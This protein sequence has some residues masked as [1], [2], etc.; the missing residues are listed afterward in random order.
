MNALAQTRTGLAEPLQLNVWALAPHA[1]HGGY[2]IDWTMWS[3]ARYED[4]VP[5][6]DWWRTTDPTIYPSEAACA[7]A[8]T[9][10]IRARTPLGSPPG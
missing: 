1:V 4:A 2:R 9:R 7:E 3:V 10:H 6:P 5:E 8:I